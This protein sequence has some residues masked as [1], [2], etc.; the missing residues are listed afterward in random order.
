MHRLVVPKLSPTHRFACLALYRALLR[1]CNDLQR[2]AP[3]LVS[4]QSHIQERFRKYKNLQSPSQTANALK[5]GYEALDLLYS[6][7]Q[8]NRHDSSLITTILSEAHVAKQ[9]KKNFQSVLSELRPVQPLSQKQIK[10]EKNRRFQELTVRPHPDAT[11]ILSR[12]RPVINGRR[13]IPVLVNACGIPFLRIKKPQP[14]SISRV[15]RTKINDRQRLADRRQMLEPEI[16]FAKDE[17]YWDSLTTGEEADSWASESEATSKEIENKLRNDTIENIRLADAMW[18]IVLA[19]R[20]LAE[21]EKQK[22]E[23]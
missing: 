16:L 1:R 15:I 18:K 6:A 14:Q 19:E 9:R 2:T 17:D 12:P 4:S 23:T 11:P 8:G 10:K 3:E 5:A 22:A 20:K 21:E 13:R 7:S